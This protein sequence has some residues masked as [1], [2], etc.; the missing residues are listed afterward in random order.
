LGAGIDLPRTLTAAGLALLTAACIDFVAPD[1]PEIGAPAVFQGNVR[2]RED[3]TVRVD[4][5][6]VPGIDED[7]FRR[8]LATDEVIALGRR[9]PPRAT[10]PNGTRGYVEEWMTTP[11]SVAGALALEAPV[12]E[13]VDAPPSIRWSGLVRVGPDTVALADGRDLVLRLAVTGPDAPMALNRSWNLQLI[14]TEG[15]FGISAD[16]VPPDSISVPADWLPDAPTG[17]F[18]AEFRYTRTTT[19][20]P[21]GSSYLGL[22]LADV[23]LGWTI[24]IV[25]ADG[26][27]GS[28]RG[29]GA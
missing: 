18:A 13:G 29:H 8:R 4:A 22:F 21:D 26:E 7:G 28:F 25:P 12:V 19:V 9:I 16:G 2:V 23:Q 20:R 6:L 3:G 5:Q 15:R 14:S 1:L 17:T 11:D 27:V 24:R 10:M